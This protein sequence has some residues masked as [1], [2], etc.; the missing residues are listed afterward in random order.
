MKNR[1]IHNLTPDLKEGL[2]LIAALAVLMGASQAR[3]Q[4]PANPLSFFP[5][6]AFEDPKVST[7]FVA[8]RL[9]AIRLGKALFW[10]MQIGS[11][12]I[13]ACASCHF[14]AGADVRLRNQLS[15]GLLGGDVAFGSAGFP[16]FTTDYT[17]TSAD[18]PFHQ[19][20]F[21][22]RQ[23]APVVR[24]IND[25]VSSQGVVV[26]DF[27]DI[28]PGFA[29]D[30]MVPIADAVFNNSGFNVRRVPPRNTPSVINAVYNHDNF[31]DGRA[32]NIFNGVNPFGHLDPAATVLEN[33]LVGLS[34]TTVRIRNA[35]LASQSVGPP[36]SDFEMSAAGRTFPKLGKKM[37]SLVPLSKQ[38]VHPEDSFLGPISNSGGK[39]LS[40]SYTQLIQQAFRSK[41]WSSDSIVTF[42]PGGEKL[43]SPNPGRPLTTDE[44]TQ[45]E[46]NFPLFFGLAVQIYES[47]LV[48]DRSRFDEFLGGNL[49]A[50]TA[51][52]QTGL[53]IFVGKGAC[54]ACHTGTSLTSASVLVIQGIE[55]PFV[56]AAGIE[57]MNMAQG[58]AFYDVGFYNISVRPTADDIGRGGTAPAINPLTGQQFPLSRSRLALLKRDG[59]LPPE[60]DAF[61]IALPA[62]DPTGDRVVVDG[63]LKTPGLRNV[64]LTGPYF[65][66]G[67]ASTLEQVIEFYSRGGNFPAA[68]IDDFDPLITQIGFNDAEQEALVA[69]LKSLTD[70][71]VRNESVPFD[72]PELLVPNGHTADGSTQ[73]LRLP[74]VGAQGRAAEGLRALQPF[75]A[76]L[77]SVAEVPSSSPAGPGTTGGDESVPGVEGGRDGGGGGGGGCFIATAAY[78]SYMADE[79]MTLRRFRDRY[80]LT[81]AAGK[82]FVKLYYTYSPP[83]ADYIAGHEVLKAAARTAL[84]PFVYSVKYPVHVL[85]III[86]ITGVIGFRKKIRG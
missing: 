75:P 36:L 26:A 23:D 29:E 32:N 25:V 46:A 38:K 16:Q 64:E 52:E 85:M 82:V 60:V 11:D 27:V 63:A 17:L 71:R 1:L 67:G 5:P 9:A 19:R 74:P 7:D 62:G 43:I 47:T 30:E 81:N 68:N 73:L 28:R 18:F 51:Q 65:H 41:W 79:V 53:G 54:I 4:V 57:F 78:G 50:L 72:H 69:F 56:E 37:L 61:V 66:N 31:W 3:G 58:S 84:A 77:V 15:P 8:D 45:M 86:L 49:N 40:V 10:D 76:P 59:L 12:G 42:G 83:I 55:D 34:E 24:D 22:D 20:E 21:Q 70:E 35:G 13:Q 80:L 2:C 33:T 14:Q 44:F 6:I 48:S 39:G